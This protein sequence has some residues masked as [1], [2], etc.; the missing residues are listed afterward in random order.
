MQIFRLL[1]YKMG[2]ISIILLGIMPSCT[3]AKE[4][5]LEAKDV[6]FFKIYEIKSSTSE[7]LKISG[8]AF[9]STMAVKNI[10][11]I[12]EKETI[13]IFV[14]LTPTK[15]GMSGNFDY[16]LPI[17]GSVNV[18]NFGTSKVIIWK[19]GEGAILQG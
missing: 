17:P 6:Q 7:E 3:L 9:H 15:A 12:Q 18:I 14:Y 2:V 5:V 13:T 19:R 8:L 11:V 1:G 16:T 10:K 4:V